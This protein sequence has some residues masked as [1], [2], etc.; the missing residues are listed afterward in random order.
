MKMIN[1]ICLLFYLSL[2]ALG[3]G[4]QKAVSSTMTID[5]Q[6]DLNGSLAKLETT[7]KDHAPFI[8]AKLAPPAT[9]NQLAELQRGL[10]GAQV[11]LLK[12]WYQ[13]HNGCL[14]HTTNILPL[15]WMLSIS[16]SLQDRKMIQGTPFV[17]AKRKGALKILD[18]GAGDGFFLDITS[19]SPRVFYHMLED[20]YPRD[21]GTLQDFIQ[22]IT[23]IHDAGLSS[24]N[25]NG[26]V[27][28]DLER[29]EKLESDYLGKLDKP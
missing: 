2:I 23:Q 10:D 22:F 18:D 13:W 17:D 27:D 29:Y 11:Q 9:D 24:E 1:K 8:H 26:T 19:K 3:C 15:G 14:D 4:R 6:K 28:F 16:E 12:L 7:L 21:F 20:P 25:K 5:E